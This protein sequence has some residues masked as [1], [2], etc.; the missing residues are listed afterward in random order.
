MPN[1]KTIVKDIRGAIN[2]DLPKHDDIISKRTQ[3]DAEPGPRVGAARSGMGLMSGC[4]VAKRDCTK[5]AS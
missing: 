1:F 5:S 4:A 3:I 2:N